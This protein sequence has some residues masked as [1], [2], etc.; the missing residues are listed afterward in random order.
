MSQ[1][2]QTAKIGMD[3]DPEV[4]TYVG[5]L[6]GT[7]AALT[8]QAVQNRSL[9]ELL[10]D[11]GWEAGRVGMN[12]DALREFATQALVRQ[13]GIPLA[14]AKLIIAK[15]WDNH[16]SDMEQIVPQAIPTAEFLGEDAI[17]PVTDPN[18]EKN[19]PA[20]PS[21]MSSRLASWKAKQVADADAI[22]G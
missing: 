14:K 6:E 4:A 1:P 2:L 19:P 12:P 10:T 5:M 20:S 8:I 15:R 7:V 21:A 9:L 16:N 13:T 11:E 17:E 3:M 18:P 22:L